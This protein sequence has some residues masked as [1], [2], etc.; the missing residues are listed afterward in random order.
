MISYLQVSRC[1]IPFRPFGSIWGLAINYTVCWKC[2]TFSYLHMLN[3]HES[4]DWKCQSAPGF[5]GA[6]PHILEKHW[7]GCTK[8]MLLKRPVPFW[9]GSAAA[10][11][12][13]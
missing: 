2:P 8:C 6:V 3:L 5:R 9:V 1:L 10:W 11:L 13:M 7:H 4:G 12:A